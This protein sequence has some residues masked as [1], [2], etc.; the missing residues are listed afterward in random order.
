MG[1]PAKYQLIC[2]TCVNLI[3]YRV[4]F[5]SPTEDWCS[6]YKYQWGHLVPLAWKPQ[7]AESELPAVCSM[8][9]SAMTSL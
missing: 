4:T 7:S 1:R 8:R 2:W 3:K 6:P 9:R 5:E